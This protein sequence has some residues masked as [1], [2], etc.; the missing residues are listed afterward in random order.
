MEKHQQELLA[1]AKTIHLTIYWATEGGGKQ[2]SLDKLLLAIKNV[3]LMYSIVIL[4]R[5]N[6]FSMLYSRMKSEK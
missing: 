3:Y 6:L 1:M 4:F 5:L 2:I